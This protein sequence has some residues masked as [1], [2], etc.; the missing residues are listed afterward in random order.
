VTW[1]VELS[2]H[3]AKWFRKADPQTARRIRDALR[4]IRTLG[5]PRAR[6]KALTGGFSGLWRYRVGDH[7]IVCDLQDAHLIVL[8]IDLNGTPR[9]P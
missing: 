4:T 8:V 2:P 6:G 1:D 5:S 9:F 3:A 7:R